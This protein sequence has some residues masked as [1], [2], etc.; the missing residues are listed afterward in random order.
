MQPIRVVLTA[1]A[2]GGWTVS[3]PNTGQA[4]IDDPSAAEFE[5]RQLVARQRDLT[6]SDAEDLDVT[7]VDERGNDLYVFDLLFTAAPVEEPGTAA[8]LAALAT[9]PPTG[10]RFMDFDGH[11]GLRCVRPGT[12]RFE[13]ISTLITHVRDRYGL[14]GNDLGFEKLWEW[15]GNRDWQERMVA[16]L[17]L[18]ATDRARQAGVPVDDVLTFVRTL[19]TTPPE[20]SNLNPSQ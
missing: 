20:T 7:V 8:S 11:P 17:L 18:M 15:A 10:C 4:T 9:A 16:H 6:W 19:M 5:A 13:A 2:D 14:D 3:V 1:S 12:S